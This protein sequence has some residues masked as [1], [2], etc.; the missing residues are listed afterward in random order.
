MNDTLQH[1]GKALPASPWLFWLTVVVVGLVFFST[2]HSPSLSATSNWTVE[3]DWAENIEEGLGQTTKMIALSV[4]MLLGVYLLARRS[5][6]PL[7]FD[8]LLTLLVL[9][10]LG[11]CALS[12]AWSINPALTVR[13]VALL[14]ACGMV[15][16]GIVKHFSAY[17]V[18]MMALVVSTGYLVTGIALEL[19]YGVFRPLGADYRFA[20]TLHPNMQGINAAVMC[21]A[22]VGMAVAEPRARKTCLLLAAIALV[23]VLLTKSRTSLG[24]LLAAGAVWA[25]MKWSVRARL[26]LACSSVTVICLSLL[27]GEAVGADLPDTLMR[28]VS[29]GR[30]EEIGSLTGRIPLWSE[31]TRYVQ[32]R[33]LLGYGYRAFW[34]RQHTMDI[35]DVMGGWQAP[36]AHSALLDTALD[37]GVPAALAFAAAALLATYRAAGTYR[38]TNDPSYGFACAMLAFAICDSLLESS[39]VIPTFALILVV[40]AALHVAMRTSFA[41]GSAWQSRRSSGGRQ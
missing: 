17:N 1:H 28:C 7:T 25:T 39:F 37:I 19:A 14:G 41:C 26:A 9:V 31:L 33:P 10:Y 36:H 21:L 22:G 24:A 4:L 15:A 5:E 13:R 18:M 35:G 27:L 30:Q 29:L 20:G 2:T 16:L 12:I 11:M 23:C 6:Q 8:N 34:D 32:E 40:C 38:L 3:E